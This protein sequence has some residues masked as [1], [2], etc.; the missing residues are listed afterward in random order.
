MVV[1]SP[2]Q[3]GV[4]IT[5]TPLLRIHVALRGFGIDGK[6]NRLLSQ[7]SVEVD[8]TVYRPLP[9]C[10]VS[11]IAR[12]LFVFVPRARS[13]SCLHLRLVSI[14]FSVF[15]VHTASR[16]LLSL[17][18]FQHTTHSHHFCSTATSHDQNAFLHR[19]LRSR[20]LFCSHRSTPPSP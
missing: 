2:A 12:L 8:F 19:C 3:S 17:S 4:P 1:C 7:P 13:H 16:A 20:S 18:P 14:P 11:D 15:Q 6:L 10:C 5:T 9:T